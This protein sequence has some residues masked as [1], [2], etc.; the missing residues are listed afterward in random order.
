[1]IEAVLAVVDSIM[2]IDAPTHCALLHS[3]WDLK[4]AQMSIN[5]YSNS[6]QTES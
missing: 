4:A 2:V 3:A 1:M 6:V 5:M